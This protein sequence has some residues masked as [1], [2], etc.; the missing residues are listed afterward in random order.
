MTVTTGTLMDLIDNIAPFSLAEDW[1]NSGLQAGDISWPVNKI[2]VALDVSMA[3]M[4]A[5]EQ[6]HADLVLTHHPLMFRPVKCIDFKSMPG[7]IIARAALEKISIISVHTNFDKAYN[8]L[9][10]FFARMIGLKNISSLCGRTYCKESFEMFSCETDFSLT[11]KNQRPDPGIGRKGEIDPPA[12]LYLFAR[13]VKNKL[14][15]ESLRMTGSKDLT[16]KTA[17]IC[18]GSGG[19]L[20]DDFFRSGADVFVTG[21]IKY[22]EARDIE[23]AGLGLIDVGH[24]QSE[25]IGLNLLAEKLDFFAKNAGINIAVR[26]FNGERDPFRII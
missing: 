9:N 14:G 16:V 2:M 4:D 11:R 15:I 25:H 7:N 12:S 18:T 26:V 19:S 5:A 10:D 20:L 1:D 13:Q 24:F 6:W 17:A 21:D 8:G 3:V 22:H 23:Q